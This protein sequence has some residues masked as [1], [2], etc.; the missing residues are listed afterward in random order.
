V[1]VH[2]PTGY[3]DAVIDY[4]SALIVD[5]VL[6]PQGAEARG[7]T[8]AILIDRLA[9]EPLGTEAQQLDLLS[10]TSQPIEWEIGGG[11]TIRHTVSVMVQTQHG[12]LVVARQLRDLIVTELIMRA[13]TADRGPMRQ[14]ADPVTGQ[15]LTRLTWSIDWRPLRGLDTPNAHAA[16]SFVLDCQLDG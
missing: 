13:R 10:V 12:D 1:T 3:A 8:R 16:V 2:R 6:T 11:M 5:H 9:V 14:T 4:P 7:A 15:Y